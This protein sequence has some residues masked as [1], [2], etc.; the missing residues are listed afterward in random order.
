MCPGCRLY[1]TVS[2]PLMGNS[3]TPQ[4]AAKPRPTAAAR[5]ALLRMHFLTFP[6][7]SRQQTLLKWHDTVAAVTTAAA[8]A[9]RQHQQK[10][11]AAETLLFGSPVRLLRATETLNEHVGSF[12]RAVAATA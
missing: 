4:P 12:I 2:A 5:W 11:L 10:V 8:E 1:K 9:A 6:R 3:T 7:A